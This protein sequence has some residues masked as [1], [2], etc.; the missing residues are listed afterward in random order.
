MVS[1][2]AGV[3]GSTR[4]AEMRSG[5]V[6]KMIEDFIVNESDVVR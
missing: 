4:Y 1:G 6:V 5:R 3:S 2:A